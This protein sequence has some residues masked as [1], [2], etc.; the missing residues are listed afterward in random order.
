[1]K[2]WARTALIVGGS[3]AAVAAGWWLVGGKIAAAVKPP[4][5]QIKALLEELMRGTSVPLW[6]A[7]TVASLESAFD[8]TAQLV[9]AR[10]DSHGLFMI[11][12][13][14]HREALEER[15]V[16]KEDLLDARTNA[17]YWR[18]LVRRLIVTAKRKGYAGDDIFTQVRLRLAG[19]AW[20]S[21][22]ATAL[23]IKARLWTRAR[24][25]R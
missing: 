3:G 20:G 22:S 23:R 11:N 15:G 5:A 17:L 13:N 8:P 25:Y 12:W 14:A 6:Y 9:T 19:I 24:R 2:P 21:S 16:S 1:M 7:L 4:P 10:E 18:D